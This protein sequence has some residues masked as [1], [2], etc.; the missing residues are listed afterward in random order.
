V[1]IF[2]NF[3]R[4]LVPCLSIDIRGNFY[5]NRPRETSASGV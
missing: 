5:R 2:S 1:E 4:R 3:L